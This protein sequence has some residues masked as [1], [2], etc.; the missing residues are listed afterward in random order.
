MRDDLLFYGGGDM[1]S[2]VQARRAQVKPAVE[3]IPKDK[4]LN[5]SEEDLIAALT[6]DL[7]LDV[8]VISDDPS[9]ETHE[10]KVDVSRDPMRFIDDRIQPFYIPGTMVVVSIAF[11]GDPGFFRIQPNSFSLNPPRGQVVRNE[12]QLSYNRADPNPDEVKRQYESD[13]AQIRS[14]LRGLGGI[15]NPTR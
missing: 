7:H 11:K 6:E 14:S 12:L 1:F 13:L 15:G 10:S 9:M 2:V 3:Q 5:A 8:P 4:L